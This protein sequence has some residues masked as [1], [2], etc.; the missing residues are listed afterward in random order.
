MPDSA[1]ARG[2]SGIGTGTRNSAAA[3]AASD[4]A[5]FCQRW[6]IRELAVF[7]SA[8]R[9]DLSPESDID[10]LVTFA[11]QADW[12]LLEHVQME[13]ELQALFN[14][15]IDLVSRRALERS[16][17]WLLRSEILRTARV[18]YPPP[19]RGGHAAR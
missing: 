16:H 3:I 9:D 15:S 17:N 11:E 5:P 2:N 6:S 18:L 8:L 19:R 12:G 10:F 1:V 14:R 13:Q 4:I 7:G